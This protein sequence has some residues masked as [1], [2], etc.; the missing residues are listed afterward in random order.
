MWM[1]NYMKK[2]FSVGIL[3]ILTIINVI[4]LVISFM[5]KV[6]DKSNIGDTATWF[7]CLIAIVTV[8]ITYWQLVLSKKHDEPEIIVSNEITK[9]IVDFNKGNNEDLKKISDLKFKV[10]NIGKGAAKKVVAKIDNKDYWA[11]RL[12]KIGYDDYN[13]DDKTIYIGLKDARNHIKTIES[14]F[15]EIDTYIGSDKSTYLYVPSF[16]ISMLRNY[17]YDNFKDLDVTKENS[18][19]LFKKIES[20]PQL[21]LNLS[22][23]GIDEEQKYLNLTIRPFADV[24][25]DEKNSK[26]I[27]LEF[28]IIAPDKDEKVNNR[29]DK[30]KNV[31]KNK[32]SFKQERISKWGYFKKTIAFILSAV[33]MFYVTVCLWLI[34][35]NNVNWLINIPFYL[36]IYE[37]IMF[38]I[39]LWFSYTISDTLYYFD[40]QLLEKN[41][42]ICVTLFS[43]LIIWIAP[44]CLSLMKIDRSEFAFYSIM[45]SYFL[46]IIV[47]IIAIWLNFL[48]PLI[49]A[50]EEQENVYTD[51]TGQLCVKKDSKSNSFQFKVKQIK[52]GNYD[53]KFYG[54]IPWKD[55]RKIQFRYNINELFKTMEDQKGIDDAFVSLTQSNSNKYT[56]NIDDFINK[57]KSFLGVNNLF[58]IVIGY[59]NEDEK[60]ERYLLESVLL[61]DKTI[62]KN[63]D[64]DENQDI[65]EKQTENNWVLREI[66]IPFIYSAGLSFLVTALYVIFHK[67]IEFRL[68]QLVNFQ[69]CLDLKDEG[70][71]RRA[72][73]CIVLG[74]ICI[75]VS[76][77]IK[78][79]IQLSDLKDDFSREQEY[80]RY[81]L[82]ILEGALL[83][84]PVLLLKDQGLSVDSSGYIELNI[85]LI[86]SLWILISW[87]FFNLVKGIALLKNWIIKDKDSDEKYPRTYLLLAIIT[88]LFGWLWGKK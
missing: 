67:Y 2:I 24:M 39:S 61:I 33:T 81:I 44:V 37:M 52:K 22:Y 12:K 38:S 46:V 87:F 54:L 27:Y 58:C 34:L 70:Q 83:I 60:K 45:I 17:V 85:S 53:Y 35:I 16:Y 65:I 71:L 18:D 62:D 31:I 55:R 40:P 21:H 42:V 32:T 86:V 14:Y 72:Y 50:L 63:E 23:E 8:S 4:F 5:V 3:G 11:K 57:F 36:N 74:F 73:I 77:L 41:K 9:S 10:V 75:Y 69:I 7:G 30:D 78:Y 64:T 47:N 29:V 25:E 19:N 82:K 80:H 15:A 76:L 13:F 51:S 48:P 59:K 49:I 26:L 68:L 6:P 1:D 66:L 28:E 79:V 88:F 84:L 43:V 56:I 20:F